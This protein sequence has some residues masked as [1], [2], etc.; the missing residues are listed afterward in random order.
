MHAD[1]L[2]LVETTQVLIME[3]KRQRI[4]G[5]RNTITEDMAKCF[6]LAAQRGNVRSVAAWLSYG[7]DVDAEL[8]GTTALVTAVASG[9]FKIVETLLRCR[10]DPN[11]V[12][13]VGLDPKTALIAAAELMRSK[14]VNV[15]LEHGADPNQCD[16]HGRTPLHIAAMS[17]SCSTPAGEQE[18]TVLCLIRGGADPERRDQLGRTPLRL[19]AQ[20]KNIISMGTLVVEKADVN[21]RC[22]R[23]F[24]A[25]HIACTWRNDQHVVSRLLEDGAESNAKSRGGV[26][27]LHLAAGHGHV[28]S[29]CSL[30]LHSANVEATT[31]A[32]TRTPLHWAAEYDEREAIDELIKSRA[33]VDQRD[34]RDRTPL[35][36]SVQYGGYLSATSLLCAGADPRITAW[37]PVHGYEL[38]REDVFA[39][40]LRVS[41]AEMLAVLDPCARVRS[42]AELGDTEQLK[43]SIEDIFFLP[44]HRQW[45]PYL[46]DMART[47]LD[48]WASTRLADE[49]ACFEALHNR[50]AS[51]STVIRR[52]QEL[53]DLRRRV[54]GF[55]VATNEGTR[56]AVRELRVLIKKYCC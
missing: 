16:Q 9:K 51:E 48:V 21:A 38:L 40:A 10:A 4:S 52:L 26:T 18:D 3:K 1:T 44:F 17:W 56:K 34:S 46:A 42:W 53:E 7:V 39:L 29:V 22:E 12:I 43:L 55:L 8:Y 20:R 47:D 36:L 6:I 11:R 28:K 13:R 41:D 2:K 24:S 23:G 54:S 15:L 19:A 32:D 50:S 33:R 5:D 35:H 27:P 45:L 14:Y 49:Q 25:L 30:V 37:S 31:F